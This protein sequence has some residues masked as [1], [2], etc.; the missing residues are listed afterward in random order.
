MQEQEGRGRE[1]ERERALGYCNDDRAMRVRSRSRT[2]KPTTSHIRLICVTD[3]R[4]HEKRAWAGGGREEGG[5]GRGAGARDLAVFAFTQNHSQIP[6]VLSFR[7][8]LSWSH[9]CASARHTSLCHGPLSH[10]TDCLGGGGGT[11]PWPLETLDS[12]P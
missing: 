1:R 3:Q 8:L 10:G 11:F 6:H 2:W 4:D 7:L 12:R 9:V 5:R